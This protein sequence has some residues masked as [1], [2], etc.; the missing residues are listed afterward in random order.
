MERNLRFEDE[1]RSNSAMKKHIQRILPA[2]AAIL[3]T[4]G[5]SS[6]QHE[7]S[8]DGLNNRFTVQTTRDDKADFAGITTYFLP[9][10]I[11][12]MEGNKTSDWTDDNAQQILTA[13]ADCMNDYGY[14]PEADKTAAQAGLQLTYIERTTYYAAW[15]NPYWSSGYWGYWDDWY[16]PFPALFGF[17][18]GTLF[19]EMV[20][21][22]PTS[23]VLEGRANKLPV[24]WRAFMSGLLTGSQRI[25]IDRTVEAVEQAFAQSPYLDKNPSNR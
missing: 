11:L 4:A 25:N 13:V 19:I 22:R 2:A 17:S 6:C 9:D 16:Y 15:N 23:T 10:K 14:T 18:S 12:L 8:T 21:L 7:P 20:D 3:L 24:V 5:I 1:T